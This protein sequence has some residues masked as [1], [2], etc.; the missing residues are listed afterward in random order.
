MNGE[1]QTLLFVSPVPVFIYGLMAQ[2]FGLFSAIENNIFRLLAQ[3]VN[4]V[5]CLEPTTPENFA[6]I[7]A[8]FRR[9]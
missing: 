3:I 5:I 4:F 8:G 2:S 9:I 6:G 1:R 7:S